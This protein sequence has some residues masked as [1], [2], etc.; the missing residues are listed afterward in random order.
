MKMQEIIYMKWSRSE[1]FSHPLS[2]LVSQTQQHSVISSSR[3]TQTELSHKRQ[4]RDL[5]PLWN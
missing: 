5:K 2:A 3:S 4:M 1:K